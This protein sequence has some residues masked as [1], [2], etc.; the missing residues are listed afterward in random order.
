MVGLEWL[1]VTQISGDQKHLEI[2]S[3]TCLVS[4]WGGLKGWAQLELSIGDFP[5]DLG[6][7]T[8]WQVRIVGFLIRQL[9]AP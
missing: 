4:G 3:F 1:R 6:F 8:E 9:E 2:S 7:L 5:C